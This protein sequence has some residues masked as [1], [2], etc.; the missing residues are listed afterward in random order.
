MPEL[1]RDIRYALRLLA[2]TPAFASIAVLTLALGIGANTAIFSLFNA[3]VLRS[4]PVQDARHLVVLRWS[5]HTR[6]RNIGSSSYGDTAEGSRGSNPSGTS[7]S[8]PFFEQVKNSGV[9]S[10]VA[11]FSSANPTA[12]SGNGPAA[13]VRTQAVTGDFFTTLGIRPALGR[14]LQPPDDDPSAPP[15]LV[16]NYAYWQKAFGGS[17]SAVGKTVKINNIPFTIVGVA[18][19][20]FLSLSFGNIY[21]LWIPMS[22]KPVINPDYFARR[23]HQTHSWWL[24]ITARLKPDVPAARAQAAVDLL[25]QNA[26]LHDE[27][28]M[29]KESDAPSL[30]LVPAQDALV[31]A[32]VHYRDQLR[33]M[34]V[35]VGIVLLIACAN[36]AGLVLGRSTARRREIAV[37]L[38]LG[39]RRTRLLRQLLTESIVLA[40]AGGALGIVLAWWGAHAIVVMIDGRQRLGLAP[41][42][43]L[44]VLAF[45]AAISIFTGVLFGL[46][47]AFRSLRLDLTPSL[48]ESAEAVSSLHHGRRRIFSLGNLLVA[49][50]AALAI[51]VLMGAGLLV[52]TL[53][54]LRNVDPGFDT[55]NILTFNL[56]P[57]LAGYQPEQ[58]DAL[59][60]DLHDQIA[61]LPGV[62]SVSYS[63]DILLA[64]SL[65]S[66]GFHYTPPGQSAP[67]DAEAD[68]M[69]VSHDFFATM[70]MPLVAGRTFTPAEYQQAAAE[71]DAQTARR[72]AKPGTIPPP[73][74]SVPVAAVVNQLFVNK[75][76]PGVN[77]IGRRF[78]DETGSDP[79]SSK[80]PGNVIVGVV[81]NALYESLR[82]EVSPTV[83]V[84][85][86]HSPAAFEVRTSSDP[87]AL[88]SPIRSLLFQRDQNLPMNDVRT[89]SEHI[90]AILS[91]ERMIAKL[92]SFFGG[93]ALLLACIG[94]YG[95]LS[96]EVSR[97]TREIG[98][99]MA[100]GADRAN[101]I[102]MVVR[103]GIA[104]AGVGT[105]AGVAVAIA[106]GHLLSKLLFGVKPT[107]PITLAA[108]VV[109]LLAVALAAA[110]IPA[111]RA[112]TVD[113]M[114]A[115]RCE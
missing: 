54:N 114:I 31:G 103:Q 29:L 62:L 80:Q 93:L 53:S 57:Q 64:G 102:Q 51:I 115:L 83:Y 70:K 110:F 6:P 25:F 30:T 59:Y 67:V 7:F 13:S 34:L 19:P 26:V 63:S 49:V 112:T 73:L 4:L 11:A 10:S 87:K 105:A 56:E 95:L 78:A 38:A 76:F 69:A 81:G 52:H 43:D 90:D 60:G 99:R 66:R 58:V 50:Q 40:L 36:V 98:I 20:N 77:P 108:V 24:L 28:P 72:N 9:F 35:A 1:A 113:P 84:P 106:I 39:A 46:A 85:L 89:Q 42:L 14:L 8:F 82:K 16:L 21:D 88:I 18:E 97:R 79:G 32:S 104:L 100:L 22:L 71:D 109:L 17:P 15:A 5:A 92:S 101:L 68:M 2:K 27:K 48:K 96:Y 37:R 65:W 33:V 55:R 45:T 12:L 61:A 47:P 41:S 91:N 107:D 75:Y 74:P 3:M 111:R 44:R 23:Y 86:A 94:L